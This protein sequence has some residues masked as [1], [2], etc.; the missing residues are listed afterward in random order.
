MSTQCRPLEKI[1]RAQFAPGLVFAAAGATSMTVMAAS[2]CAGPSCRFPA[3]ICPMSYRLLCRPSCYRSGRCWCSSRQHSHCREWCWRLYSCWYS[4]ALVVAR[5]L[6][7]VMC[8]CWSGVFVSW[9][10]Y[11][12][13]R[14]RSSVHRRSPWSSMVLVWALFVVVLDGIG[15]DGVCRIIGIVL[16]AHLLVLSP[17]RGH[18]LLY[19]VVLA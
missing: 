10:V 3:A 4:I 14:R 9:P 19:P 6:L 16:L 17:V 2:R 1:C 15:T 8:W 18:S 7:L 13:A 12:P 11:G 5:S